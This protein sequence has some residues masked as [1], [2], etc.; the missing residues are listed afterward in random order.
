MAE[1]YHW[2]EDI[3]FDQ[4]AADAQFWY[5]SAAKLEPRLGLRHSEPG[6]ELEMPFNIAGYIRA[7]KTALAEA[8]DDESVAS[9]LLRAPRHRNIIRRIQT[10]A[11]FPYGEIHDNLVGQECRPI[12]LLRCKLSFFGASKFDPKSDKWTRITLY[13]GAPT[14]DELATNPPEISDDW[15]FPLHPDSS[16]PQS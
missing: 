4:P 8:E 10:I 3:D 7:L 12:D 2:V 15:L 6:A 13:Q 5:V 14:A 9:F 11:K 16:S 1:H